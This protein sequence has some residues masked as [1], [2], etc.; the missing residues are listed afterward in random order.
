MQYIYNIVVRKNA[1]TLSAVLILYTRVAIC[2]V[3][4]SFVGICTRKFLCDISFFETDVPA[5]IFLSYFNDAE[6][7]RVSKFMFHWKNWLDRKQEI[8]KEKE[9][10]KQATHRELFWGNE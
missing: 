2:I 4:C 6:Y 7:N 8:G 1:I 3:R 5:R 9:E 10:N